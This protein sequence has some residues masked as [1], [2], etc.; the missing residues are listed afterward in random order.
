[1]RLESRRRSHNTCVGDHRRDRPE[2]TGVNEE[3]LD[4]TLVRHV[5]AYRSTPCR[6]NDILRSRSIA[7]PTHAWDPPGSCH[8]EAHGC[9]DTAPS[10]GDDT[11]PAAH[12]ATVPPAVLLG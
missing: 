1:E 9:A 10:S 5:S 2:L 8:T 7:D 4:I 3:R 12:A 6:R 11:D